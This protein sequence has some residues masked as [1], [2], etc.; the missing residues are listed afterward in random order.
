MTQKFNMKVVNQNQKLK[1]K[2]IRL[3]PKKGETMNFKDIKG[4]Y[5]K[6]IDNG[7]VKPEEIQMVGMSPDKMRHLNSTD[8]K[9]G[10]LTLKQLNDDFKN[11]DDD[12]Y[13]KDSARDIEKFN[14]FFFVDFIIIPT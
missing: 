11:F 4:F 3:T 6:L 5:N 10:M 9:K 12:E 2:T 1:S 7:K 8:R 14:K 13:Y